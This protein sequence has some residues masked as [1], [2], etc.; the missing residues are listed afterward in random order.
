MAYRYRL[1]AGTRHRALDDVIVLHKIFQRLM[2]EVKKRKILTS[3]ED[4]A[5]FVALGNALENALQERE[6][7]LLFQ[8]GIH[9]LLSPYSRVYKAFVN[10]FPEQTADLREKLE[11]ISLGQN[12]QI[13]YYDSDQ[14][15]YSRVLRMANN[16][17][18]L[19]IDEAISEFLAFIALIN[20]QDNLEPIDA[21]SLLTLYAAKGLEFDKVI[22]SGL[23]DENI[24]SIFTYRQDDQDDRP[25]NKKMDEQKRLL[26]VGI[27]RSKS[28]VIFTLVRNR[29]GRRRKSSPFLDSI[30]SKIDIKL[31]SA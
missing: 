30:K 22:I 4:F 26:Y 10:T 13:K 21:V 28:E 11:K 5:E 1:D 19:P 14:E 20:T 7:R 2:M 25:L 29:F 15:F 27:T 24:P 23:E 8:A 9:K 16:Y 17:R 31:Y 12:L 6:D 3:G 18:K